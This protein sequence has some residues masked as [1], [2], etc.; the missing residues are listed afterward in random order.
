MQLSFVEMNS[1]KLY[2]DNEGKTLV[3]SLRKEREC[4]KRKSNMQIKTTLVGLEEEETRMAEFS[5]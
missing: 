3:R 4:L 5:E 1:R 2:R